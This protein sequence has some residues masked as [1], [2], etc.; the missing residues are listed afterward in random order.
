MMWS[1][2]IRTPL[3]PASLT[4]TTNIS[5]LCKSKEN[6]GANQ[7]QEKL[8]WGGMFN[9]RFQAE[10]VSL[11]LFNFGFCVAQKGAPYPQR[12]KVLEVQLR[13]GQGF[14]TARHCICTDA[15]AL[16]QLVTTCSISRHRIRHGISICYL[17]KNQIFGYKP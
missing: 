2:I 8:L 15:Y 12:G 6:R 7:N 14:P 10:I 1:N 3:M 13:E 11:N 4:L 16:K 5:P 9:P 17:N